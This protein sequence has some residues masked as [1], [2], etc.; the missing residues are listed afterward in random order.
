LINSTDFGIREV[1]MEKKPSRNHQET[2]K[3]PSRNHQETA[4]RKGK[5][6]QQ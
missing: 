5:E 4:I 1:V 3:K 2:I 6:K